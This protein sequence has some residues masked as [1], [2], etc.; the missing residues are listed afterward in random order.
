MAA[1]REEGKKDHFLGKRE[2]TRFTLDVMLDVAANPR[3][4]AE[5]LPVTMHNVSAEGLSFWSRRKLDLRSE[6]RIRS[7]R[8]GEPGPWVPA[9]VAH[10]TQ[11]VRGYLV[12]VV[13]DR[14]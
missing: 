11:S 14:G 8:D 10:C 4:P 6:L 13:F 5:V 12:G 2:G 3:K 9:I 1:A 7:F